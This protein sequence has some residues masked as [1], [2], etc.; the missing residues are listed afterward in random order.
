MER[1]I[2]K[3]ELRGNVGQDARISQVGDNTVVRF[4]MAT[5]E[6]FKDRS[7]ALKEETTWH[8]VTAWNGRGM[9][10]FGQIKKGVCVSV[11]GRVKISKYTNAEGE[12]K[13]FYEVLAS[14]IVIEDSNYSQKS[15]SLPLQQRTD[16][17]ERDNLHL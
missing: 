1:C 13:Q 9:P 6:T 3:I 12:E 15:V 11:L 2:N 16:N 4:N 8:T 10:D 5:N 17:Y 14:R 7:G